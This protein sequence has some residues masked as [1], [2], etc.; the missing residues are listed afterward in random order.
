M[1]TIQNGDTGLAARNKINVNFTEVGV[2][3][4]PIAVV[5]TKTA[6]YTLVVGDSATVLLIDATGALTVTLPNNLPVGF[7][8]AVIQNGTGQV[9]FAAASGA[10]LISRQNFTKTAGQNA[11]ASLIVTANAGGSAAKYLLNGDGA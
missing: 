1:Q 10:T 11:T 3:I 4:S 6:S 5:Q 2:A 9:T 7:Q 8:V